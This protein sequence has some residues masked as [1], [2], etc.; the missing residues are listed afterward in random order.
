MTEGETE[1]ERDISS[2]V[3]KN[4]VLRLAVSVT[5]GHKRN[6]SSRA[7]ASP[8]SETLWWGPDICILQSP[9]G[10]LM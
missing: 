1:C 2:N 4:V 5:F 10:A 8:E 9:P 7:P 3:F 6:T